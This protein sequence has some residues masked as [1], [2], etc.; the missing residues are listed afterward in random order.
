VEPEIGLLAFCSPFD[1]IQDVV[2]EIVQYQVC[3]QPAVTVE[4][5]C[6]PVSAAQAQP[7]VPAVERFEPISRVDHLK[8]F[9][10]N[11]VEWFDRFA[12]TVQFNRE[13]DRLEGLPIRDDFFECKSMLK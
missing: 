5:G 12:R 2:L 10:P 13:T 1:D 4:M 7:D 6:Q 8:C 9:P 11:L 3:P